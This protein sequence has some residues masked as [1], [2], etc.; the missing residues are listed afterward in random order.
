M[1]IASLL[2]LSTPVW[3]PPVAYGTLLAGLHASF[4]ILV[5]YWFVALCNPLHPLDSSLPYHRPQLR[6]CVYID[7]NSCR[8][9]HARNPLST[10]RPTGRERSKYP[11]HT[12]ITTLA[13]MSSNVGSFPGGGDHHLST[14]ATSL[15]I[16]GVRCIHWLPVVGFLKYPRGTR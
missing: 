13:K 9:I 6:S 7:L 10:L 11:S 3:L 4:P 1:S 14:S 15:C 5:T 8:L 16:H 12:G 2:T